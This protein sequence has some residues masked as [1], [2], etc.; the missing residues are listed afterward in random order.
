[1][2]NMNRQDHASIKTMSYPIESTRH[3]IV[4]NDETREGN[5]LNY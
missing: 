1:M 4:V 2:S 3:T 5:K